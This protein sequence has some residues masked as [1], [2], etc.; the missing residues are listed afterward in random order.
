MADDNKIEFFTEDQV[1]KEVGEK[2]KIYF[3][4]FSVLAITI[5]PLM[6]MSFLSVSSAKNCVVSAKK[7][8]ASFERFQEDIM[9]KSNLSYI[10]TPSVTESM[11]FSK[12][13]KSNFF[14]NNIRIILSATF[15]Y[16]GV[17]LLVSFFLIVFRKDRKIIDFGKA[18]IISVA[19]VLAS[20]L[21]Q[22]M[23]LVGV[24]LSPIISYVTVKKVL[25]TD[26]FGAII[27]VSIIGLLNWFLL[28]FIVKIFS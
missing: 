9:K 17:L 26:I 27:F 16:I 5:I 4:I 7:E 14:T 20:V 18:I 23:G 11:M 8:A 2:N 1:K 12:C 3:L 15:N 6:S 24:I 22:T 28:T 25:G 21:V 13:L 10:A 19:I